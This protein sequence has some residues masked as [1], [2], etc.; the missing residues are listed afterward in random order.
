[1]TQ[2]KILVPCGPGG[3]DLKSVHHALALAERLQAHVLILQWR[4]PPE[5]REPQSEW[6]GEA[7]SDVI[8]NARL[9][10]LSLSHLTVTG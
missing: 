5:D 10:G 9:A 3:G 2:M 7:L 8:A 1:M 6:L 4:E